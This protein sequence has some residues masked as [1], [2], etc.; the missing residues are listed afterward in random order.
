MFCV[1]TCVRQSVLQHLCYRCCW[2]LKR[3]AAFISWSLKSFLLRR[4]LRLGY[5]PLYL[6]SC[7]SNYLCPASFPHHISSYSWKN[8]RQHLLLC[9]ARKDGAVMAGRV[10][11]L[12]H[13]CCID[14]GCSALFFLLLLAAAIFACPVS[15]TSA[16][17]GTIKGFSDNTHGGI[18]ALKHS[19]DQMA[20]CH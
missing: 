4:L 11:P 12:R 10:I 8:M 3:S 6:H 1:P 5:W 16:S 17:R 2:A 14:K 15:S 7:Y 19:Y 18:F 13:V 20:L 9:W